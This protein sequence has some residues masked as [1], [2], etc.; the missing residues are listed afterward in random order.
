MCGCVRPNMVLLFANEVCP[1]TIVAPIFD[2]KN[3]FQTTTSLFS[4]RYR[5][6]NR[7]RARVKQK[8]EQNKYIFTSRILNPF[9]KFEQSK[10]GI[11]SDQKKSTSKPK[12]VKTTTTT[13]K[14]NKRRNAREPISYKK[15]KREK[16]RSVFR[17][18]LL[19]TQLQ[20]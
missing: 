8:D 18:F 15:K 19:E 16:K 11:Q 7:K 17:F 3:L 14:R 6:L 4:T 1:S 13:E 5:S 12:N 9:Y 10:L 20:G 2:P